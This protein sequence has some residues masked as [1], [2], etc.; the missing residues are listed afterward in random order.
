MCV[1]SAAQVDLNVCLSVSGVSCLANG[2]IPEGGLSDRALRDRGWAG[3]RRTAW[4]WVIAS[5]GAGP[6][7]ATARC[8]LLVTRANPSIQ[9]AELDATR[10]YK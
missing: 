8:T 5:L 10:V 9:I 2:F 1:L 6:P 7:D 3:P 4:A